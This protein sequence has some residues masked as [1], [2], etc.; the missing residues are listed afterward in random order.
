MVSGVDDEG[1]TMV[2]QVMGTAL[3]VSVEDGCADVE[4]GAGYGR[5]EF[6]GGE[7]LCWWWGVVDN[8]VLG[9]FV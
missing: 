9:K 3:A 8:I 7:W 1:D 2:L 5:W 6:C 4:S